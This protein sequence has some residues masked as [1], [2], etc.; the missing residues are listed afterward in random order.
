MRI[1]D[2][3]T[4]YADAVEPREPVAAV[5]VVEHS[6]AVTEVLPNDCDMACAPQHGH[7]CSRRRAWKSVPARHEPEIA[8]GMAEHLDARTA[9]AEQARRAASRMLNDFA[10]AGR[11]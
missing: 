7:S 10:A 1:D 6:G 3:K 5:R 9:A 11:I 2:C 8:Y 4:G